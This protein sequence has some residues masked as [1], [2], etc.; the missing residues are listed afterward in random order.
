MVLV[1]ILTFSLILFFF[2]L[3]LHILFDFVLEKKQGFL[4]YKNDIRKGRKIGIFSKGLTHTFG[5]N[6]TFS[7]IYFFKISLNIL[8]AYLQ[9]RKQPF[10]GYKN[11]SIKKS[12]NLDFLKGLT[13]FGQNFNIFSAFAF[14]LE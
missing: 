10:L 2:K 13:L 5:Q 3:G 11:D 7:L 4:D 1:K 8:F 14:F 9:G 12:K 6:L